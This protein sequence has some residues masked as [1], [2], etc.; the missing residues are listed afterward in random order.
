NGSPGEGWDGM[1]RG[2]VVP[3]GS[4]VWKINATFIDGEIWDGQ[5]FSNGN[6]G[7]SGT[8]MVLH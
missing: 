1:Y 7:N 8:V 5:D 3:Q 4:Y 6:R 2:K